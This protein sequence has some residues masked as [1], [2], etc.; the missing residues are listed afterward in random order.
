MKKHWCI[1]AALL[2]LAPFVFAQSDGEGAG[3]QRFR[4]REREK[5]KMVTVNGTLALK[6]GTIA[7]ESGG[8][9]YYVPM[10]ERYTGF[11]EGLK[12]NAKVSLEGY[13]VKSRRGESSALLRPVKMTLNGKNYDFPA[14][15]PGRG[16]RAPHGRARFGNRCR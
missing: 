12:E 3:K 9:D 8:V 5:P 11:V 1:F 13:R 6:N 10:L 15:H 16:K 4:T 2:A 7:V 14:G